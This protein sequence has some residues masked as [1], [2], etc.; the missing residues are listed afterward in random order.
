MKIVGIEGVQEFS[1]NG[2]VGRHNMVVQLP[3]GE[4]IRIPIG[5]DTYTA[6]TELGTLL[7]KFTKPQEDQSPCKQPSE[8]VAEEISQQDLLD[9]AKA[10]VSD[11]NE[12]SVQVPD[13]LELTEELSTLSS[14]ELVAL[15]EQQA[16][17]IDKLIK[18][19]F[20]GEP[21]NVMS[22]LGRDPPQSEGPDVIE[23]F[24]DTSEGD[25]EDIGE[26]FA[27]QY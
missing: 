2:T 16:N 13:Q 7:D 10:F 18:V 12:E 25:D 21:E 23:S 8:A 15:A 9:F 20:L 5:A 11:P 27:E 24:E 17:P 19:G 4:G 14:D 6:L 22:A 26:E 3:N 1:D